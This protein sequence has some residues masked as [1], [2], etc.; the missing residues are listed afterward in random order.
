LKGAGI[1]REVRGEEN[2]SDH[3]PVWVEL[4]T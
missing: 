1:D 2:A 3:A 4:A